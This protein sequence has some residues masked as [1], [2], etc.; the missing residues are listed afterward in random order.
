MATF[1]GDSPQCKRAK[2]NENYQL[3]SLEKDDTRKA[4]NTDIIRRKRPNLPPNHVLLYTILNPHYPITTEVIN[5]ISSRIG[6]VNR[7]VIFR[8]RAVQAMVEYPLRHM[9]F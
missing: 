6:K 4:E 3:I 1:N 9:K 8:K 7:I 2:N 5:N